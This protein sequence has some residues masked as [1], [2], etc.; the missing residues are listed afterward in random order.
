MERFRLPWAIQFPIRSLALLWLLLPNSACFQSPEQWLSAGTSH[1]GSHLSPGEIHTYSIR[2][3]IGHFARIHYELKG[4]YAQITFSQPNQRHSI[5]RIGRENEAATLTVLADAPGNLRLTIRSLEKEGAGGSYDLRLVDQRNAL[6]V[7][8][9]RVSA[10]RLFAE[11]EWLESEFTAET[12]RRAIR[13]YDEALADWRESDETAGAA[14]ALQK[15]AAIM[16]RLGFPYDALERFKQ[17]LSLSEQSA[18]P[19]LRSE[20]LSE[21][22]FLYS[23]LGNYAKALEYCQQAREISR[24]VKDQRTEAIALNYLSEAYLGIGDRWK[25]LDCN[26]QALLLWKNLPD[27]QGIARTNYYLGVFQS[28]LG[29]LAK[30]AASYDNALRL[31]LALNDKRGEFNTRVYIAGLKIR[32]GKY[33][34]ALDG[35]HALLSGSQ[36]AGERYR[37]AVILQNTGA[38]YYLMGEKEKALGYFDR[39][40]KIWLDIK[41]PSQEAA[42]LSLI[43]WT[44]HLM[45]DDTRAIN[46][47]TCALSVTS[48]IDD[49]KYKSHILR[50]LGSIFSSQGKPQTAIK[51]YDQALFLH[52]SN[53]ERQGESQTLN[54][55]G[56]L[57]LSLGQ[58][59]KAISR[60]QGALAINRAISSYDDEVETLYNIAAAEE[61]LKKYA[62]AIEHIEQALERA[63]RLRSNVASR[64]LQAS[65]FATVQRHFESEIRL[66]MLRSRGSNR[67]R[68][69]SRAFLISE[70]AR[71]RSLLEMLAESRTDL[72]AGANAGLLDEEMRTRQQIEAV[73]KER[74]LLLAAKAPESETKMADLKLETLLA[75]RDRLDVEIRSQSP[76]YATLAN[77]HHTGLKEL[78][79]QLDADTVLLEY[80]LGKEESYLWAVTADEIQGHTLPGE[81]LIQKKAE[82]VYDLIS[83]RSGLELSSKDREKAYW[84]A[85]GQLSQILLAPIS[86]KLK[87]R[88]LLVV[89]DGILQYIPFQSLPA[90]ETTAAAGRE[91]YPLVLDHEIVYQP[92]ASTLAILRSEPE[93]RPKS[94]KLIAIFADPVFESDDLRLSKKS[95]QAD[96]QTLSLQNQAAGRG[97]EE[98]A[99]ARL[100]FSREEARGVESLIGR[101]NI[102]LFTDFDANRNAALASRLRQYRILHFA[103]H[104][105]LDSEH[106][107]LSSIVLS[108]YDR[109]GER[110]SGHLRLHD[111]YNLELSADLVVLSACETALG[112]QIKGEG[113]I[114][115]TRGFMY[116]G[117][118]R[119]MASLWKVSDRSTAELMKHFYQFHLKEGLSPAAALQKAQ[120]TMWQ[121]PEWRA[122]YHWA[123]FVL[124]G[125]Y[126]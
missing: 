113:L 34:E 66:L 17:A 93:R 32:S 45:K 78:Q 22:G 117:A 52:R 86:P 53:G 29:D 61:R 1:L 39:A 123:G 23:Q 67:P 102:D 4:T 56:K 115:L 125:E 97:P 33:Q 84:A 96:P 16:L 118:S 121:K 71:S 51:Y 63:E 120:I 43:G 27:R 12:S 79:Q 35:Y 25:G 49:R 55:I 72:H 44:H 82:P 83:R 108:L 104:G 37:E 31:Y 2:V 21:F 95:S 92:S 126:Q 100:Y 8:L 101:E 81:A 68:Y 119:V 98:E 13:K 30:A 57:Y 6:P 89:A 47:I 90:P 65:Y 116:A 46:D 77:S 109:K 107:E 48:A 36:M 20:I 3:P 74:S 10:D 42:T 88:R 54:E 124:Q 76:R 112:K 75:R 41:N 7:D 11:A 103:T 19:L 40:L 106:P 9:K 69:E 70:R 122:P 80:Y 111:I 87:K 26:Q 5:V 91:P 14:R 73:L 62:R 18:S 38:V 85:A 94:E 50:D 60:F 59:E 110:L 58:P 24:S 105:K 99:Y 28:D 114:G 64:N 15:S